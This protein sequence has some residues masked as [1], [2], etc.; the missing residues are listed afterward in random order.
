MAMA[1]NRNR[2][3]RNGRS[4]VA[5]VADIVPIAGNQQITGKIGIAPPPDH[6][7]K[8]Q[9]NRIAPAQSVWGGGTVSYAPKQ[10]EYIENEG[11]FVYYWGVPFPSKTIAPVEAIHAI[12]ATKRLVMIALQTL[13]LKQ[14]R[15]AIIL[16]LLQGSRGR[17]KILNFLCE[18]FVGFAH[19]TVINFYLKDEYYCGLVK[20]IRKFVERVL[21]SLNVSLEL[22]ITVA[23]MIGMM[24]EY[25]NAY[26]WRIQDLFTETSKELL[27]ENLP[28]ELNR[29]I[30]ILAEREVT[31]DSGVAGRFSSGMRLIKY[32]WYVPSIRKT[33]RKA[34][35]SMEIENCKLD[36]ADIYHTCLFGDY[37]TQGKTIQERMKILEAYHGTDMKKWPPRI[38]IQQSG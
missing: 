27:M 9:R 4:V 18:K 25:D 5:V 3:N 19:V 6:I 10:A 12:N 13:S 20:E 29:L 17:T 8:Y 38:L 1:K 21:I 30:E 31:K 28:R 36:E 32:M 22:A 35:D 34:I 26:R 7:F 37:N 11:N 24:F 23:E 14:L 16:T 15:P 33:L 2:H